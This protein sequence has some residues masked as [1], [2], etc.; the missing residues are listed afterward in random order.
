MVAEATKVSLGRRRG[1]LGIP[2]LEL[3]GPVEDHQTGARLVL[4][5]HHDADGSVVDFPVVSEHAPEARLRPTPSN[6]GRRRCADGPRGGLRPT[7]IRP[8]FS[9][10]LADLGFDLPAEIFADGDIFE[11][12]RR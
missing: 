11:A 1:Q 9:E 8:S 3:V 10:H 12:L 7:G 6:A 4:P 5:L 2:D